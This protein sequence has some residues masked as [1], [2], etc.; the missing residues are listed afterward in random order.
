MK[1]FLPS[2]PES[3]TLP[4]LFKRY[5]GLGKRITALQQVIMREEGPFEAGTR[6][7]IAAYVSALNACDYCIGSHR[8]V[9]RNFGVDADLL[10]GLVGDL[11][12]ASA[13]DKLKPVLAYVRKLTLEPSKVV[14]AD[15]DA[16]LAAGWDETAVFSAALICA[17]FSFMNRLVFATGLPA[18]EAQAEGGGRVLYEK[19]YTGLAAALGLDGAD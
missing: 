13:P 6:E 3:A 2:L 19:G 4:D 7:L 1:P 9:A 10:E 8:A 16:I 5:P 15:V 17:S 18:S 11:D 14:Q 12:S